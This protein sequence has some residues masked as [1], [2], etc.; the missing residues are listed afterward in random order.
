MEPNASLPESSLANEQLLSEELLLARHAELPPVPGSFRRRVLGSA[1]RAAEARSAWK[2]RALG[3]L[4]VGGLLGGTVWRIGV[5]ESRRFEKLRLDQIQNNQINSFP[6]MSVP[7]P[8]FPLP[9]VEGESPP[10]GSESIPVETPIST[11]TTPGPKTSDT[12]AS[13]NLVEQ[14]GAE[15][16]PA[17]PTPPAVP[18]PG[19]PGIVPDEVPQPVDPR[20]GPLLGQFETETTRLEEAFRQR[21]E[22][23]ALMTQAR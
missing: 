12:D 16:S 18:N 9:P 17:R 20:Q 4:T 14:P 3:L 22:K 1:N 8:T 6:P 10:R 15:G 7:Q 5:L 19:Q 21:Q 13:E 2:W 23:L 11:P